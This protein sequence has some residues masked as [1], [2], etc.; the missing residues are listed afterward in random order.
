MVND[1]E[2]HEIVNCYYDFLKINSKMVRKE[3]G[4]TTFQVFLGTIKRFQPLHKT[5]INNR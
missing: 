1:G 4:I 5:D 2:I 3:C